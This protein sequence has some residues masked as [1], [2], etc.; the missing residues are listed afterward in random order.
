VP[1]P[2]PTPAPKAPF[3]AGYK[4]GF[5]IQSETG[6]FV[7]KLAGY[8]Q[9]DGRFMPGD[10]AEALADQF[11]VRRARPIVQGTV[12]KYFDFYVN[13]DFGGGTAVL[14]DA[15]LDVRFTPKLR[16]RLGKI[17]TPFGIE[18]LQS[19]QSLLF[20]ERALP[21]NLVPNRDVGL[22][23]HGELLQGALGYQL[24]VLNGVAD[25][26]S[27]DTDNN[28]SKDLAGR[29]FVQPWRTKGNSPLRGL[30]FGVA[31]TTG[32]GTGPLRGYSSVSQVTVFSYANT[33]TASGDRRRWTPQLSFFLGPAGVLAEYVRVR[34]EV[35]KVEPGQPDASARMTNSAWSVTGSWLVTGED[36]TYG[37]VKPKSFFVPSAG[38]WGAL[39]LVARFNRMDV[40]EKTF[41]GGFADPAKSVRRARAWGAG[42]NWIWNDNLKYVLD[43]ERTAF[44]GGS[45]EGGDRPTEDSIQ[46]RLQLSF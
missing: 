29:L 25:G 6:D 26:G 37:N 20:V 40:D 38:K 30:G 10:E 18:R 23:V 36:A 24:A 1:S 8:A 17:K 35:R 33:V 5:V 39:Q 27:A 19:G 43:Y 31:A 16:F 7:L 34:H 14:Q 12:A 13:P 28:D 11:L 22:Q 42:L 45:T 44:R 15:Y 9:A 41:R 32:N 46:T 4:N 21:N 3:V 2:T